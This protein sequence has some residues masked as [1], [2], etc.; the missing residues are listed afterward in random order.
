[1]ARARARENVSMREKR[2]V[3]MLLKRGSEGIKSRGSIFFLRLK[4]YN[5]PLFIILGDLAPRKPGLNLQ[6]TSRSFL[7]DFGLLLSK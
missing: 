5:T 2:E 1:M 6:V 4:G 3:V 7:V